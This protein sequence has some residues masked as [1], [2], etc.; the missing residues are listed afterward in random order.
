M[1][2]FPQLATGAAAVYPVTRTNTTR[3]V[4]NALS[5]GSTVVLADPDAILTH[6]EL[7]ATGLTAAEWNAVEALFQAVSGRL[8]T[9]TFL[10]PAGN[11]LAHSE[12]FGAAEWSNGPSI[13]LTGGIADPLGSTGAMHAVNT[14]VIAEAVAQ[15][16]AVA[17]NF[18]YSLSVWA[19]ASVA[20]NM[21]LFATT[22]GGSATQ[23]F[24]LSSQW[25]RISVR[26]GL[27]QNTTS[28]TFGVQL[29]ASAAVDLFGMQ[30][31]AQTGMSD[32][33]KTISGGVYFKARFSDDQLT[34]RAQAT[35]VYDAVIRVVS[36]G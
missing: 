27:G 36:R 14:G 4:I 25:K 3:T 23:T 6:W 5:D 28:V 18:Q 15:T 34:V 9:F 30:V 8:E 19:R 26:A 10:D 12:E 32:Y 33:K 17:G 2:V 35:D 29:D 7:R 16:L 20:V 22:S 21:A 1:L 13:Q 24:A 31:E 11:L